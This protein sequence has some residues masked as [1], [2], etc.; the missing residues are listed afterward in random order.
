MPIVIKKQV[1]FDFLGEEYKDAYLTFKSIPLKDYSEFSQT[2]KS[3]KDD[4]LKAADYMLGVLKNYFIEGSF[5]D[6][7]KVVANDLDALDPESVIKCFLTF[8]GQDIT[9][10]QP[11]EEHGLKDV[12][13]TPSSTNQPGQTS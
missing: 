9:T 4:D 6:A 1:K 12:S 7:D 13:T 11:G 8:T 3:V 5:P 2:L 10:E